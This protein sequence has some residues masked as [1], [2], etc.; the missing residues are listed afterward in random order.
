MR[1]ITSILP[2]WYAAVLPFVQSPGS[3]TSAQSGHRA[4]LS[5][6]VP[7]RPSSAAPMSG[8]G[9]R[10][11]QSARP[12]GVHLARVPQLS[13][14]RP[15]PA[16]TFT[17]GVGLTW[18]NLSSPSCASSVWDLGVWRPPI[19]SYLTWPA[20]CRVNGPLL[21]AAVLYFRRRALVT[22]RPSLSGVRIG[23]GAGRPSWVPIHC[24]CFVSP[25]GLP[26][27]RWS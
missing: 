8:A 26:C 16:F 1:G 12:Q 6:A 27:R 15:G 5:P 13:K 10:R 4:A 22:A 17:N 9:N 21:Q 25:S 7:G 14:S 11:R 24:A 3:S 20:W 23:A 19:A 2:H 18:L